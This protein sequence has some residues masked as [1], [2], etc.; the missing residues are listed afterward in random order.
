[1]PELDSVDV[2]ATQRPGVDLGSPFWELLLSGYSDI[3]QI[4]M[5]EFE[6][7]FNSDRDTDVVNATIRNEDITQIDLIRTTAGPQSGPTANEIDSASRLIVLAAKKALIGADGELR[8]KYASTLDAT[9]PVRWC[10][11][12]SRD[13]YAQLKLFYEDSFVDRLQSYGFGVWN[14]VLSRIHPATHMFML[15]GTV[16]RAGRSLLYTPGVY[17]DILVVTSIHYRGTESTINSILD[18]CTSSNYGDLWFLPT[19]WSLNGPIVVPT[20]S[21]DVYKRVPLDIEAAAELV[22][23]ALNAENGPARLMAAELATKSLFLRNG[24][25]NN[26]KESRG[27][28]DRFNATTPIRFVSGFLA[29]IGVV[30]CALPPAGW[31][32][33]LW[34][35][36]VAVVVEGVAALVNSCFVKESDFVQS[37]GVGTLAHNRA[38]FS[39]STYHDKWTNLIDLASDREDLLTYLGQ[40]GGF[41]M[42]TGSLNSWQPLTDMPTL[43]SYWCNPND[44]LGTTWNFMQTLQPG[45]YSGIATSGYLQS[46]LV[47]TK[48]EFIDLLQT[49]NVGAILP[50]GYSTGLALTTDLG[51]TGDSPYDKSYSVLVP[52]SEGIKV[53]NVKIVGFRGHLDEANNESVTGLAFEAGFQG[54]AIHSDKLVDDGFYVLNAQ[55]INTLADSIAA[56]GRSVE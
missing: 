18:D 15:N 53:S 16:D 36:G 56:K 30:C 51:F 37:F 54:M 26:Y 25:V 23:K 35:M 19:A 45:I 29:A 13:S 28:L 2:Y 14:R 7:Y 34:F 39:K 11:Y 10:N 20:Q 44:M 4:M 31:V 8:N 52:T 12:T 50:A 1:M 6:A 43:V 40:E 22:N 9:L 3:H 46:G 21:D 17:E 49:L 32:V 33:G 24:F 41:L 5:D 55:E 27:L 48:Q 42:D 47:R 38:R